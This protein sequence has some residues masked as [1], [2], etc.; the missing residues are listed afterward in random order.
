M[1]CVVPIV[2]YELQ[3]LHHTKH[4]TLFLVFFI[5]YLHLVIWTLHLVIKKQTNILTQLYGR[6]TVADRRKCATIE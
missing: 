2:N 1:L 4:K 3:P 6:S 5:K